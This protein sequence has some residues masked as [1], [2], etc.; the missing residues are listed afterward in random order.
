MCVCACV[1]VHVCVCAYVCGTVYTKSTPTKSD[2]AQITRQESVADEDD[3]ISVR[4]I[5]QV[6]WPSS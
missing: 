4:S 5:R 2:D 3:V 6:F 1:C